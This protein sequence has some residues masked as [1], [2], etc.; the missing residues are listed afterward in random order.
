MP[1]KNDSTLT[2]RLPKSDKEK[3]IY[4]K[5]IAFHSHHISAL[6]CLM[7]MSKTSYKEC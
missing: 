4:Q 7:I 1:P 5:G 3:F 6:K 2:I